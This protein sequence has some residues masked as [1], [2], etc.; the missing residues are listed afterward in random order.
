MRRVRYK[1]SSATLQESENARVTKMEWSG[2]MDLKHRPPGPDEGGIK[3][4]PRNSSCGK[5]GAPYGCLCVPEMKR[6]SGRR[7]FDHLQSELARFPLK[8][9]DLPRAVLRVVEG[10]SS[11]HMLHPIAQ[12]AVDQ[13]GQLGRHGLDRHG[14]AQPGSQATEL[15]SQIRIAQ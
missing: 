3:H 5:L 4:L 7:S 9:G 14:C 13:A 10:C 6:V 1:F 11:I 12:Q 8:M 15:R 2:R